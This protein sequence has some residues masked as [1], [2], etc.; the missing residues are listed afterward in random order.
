VDSILRKWGRIDVLHNNVG[1]T[2][3]DDPVSASEESWHRVMDVNITSVFLT[4]KYVLPHMMNQKS[5][6]IINIS[7]TASVQI[8]QHPYF[9]YY[10]SKSGV[11]H[12]TRALAVHYAPHGIR[13]NAVLPGVMD[14]PLIYQQMAGQFRDTEEM[15]RSRNAA[16]PMGHMGTAWDVAHAALFLASDEAKYVTGVCLPVDGGKSCAG[17]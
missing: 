10:A 15:I 2:Q 14:T 3:M 4:C 8:N 12:L 6:A 16:S 1:I 17:R 11:N 13:A 5:G 7:S 9:S